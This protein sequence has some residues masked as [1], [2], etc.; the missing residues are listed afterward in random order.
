MQQ[1][2]FSNNLQNKYPFKQKKRDEKECSNQ[3]SIL[4]SSL[5]ASAL[6]YADNKLVSKVPNSFTKSILQKIER[7]T[8][9]I[10]PDEL[11]KFEEDFDKIF[12]KSKLQDCGVSVFKCNDFIKDADKIKEHLKKHIEPKWLNKYPFESYYNTILTHLKTENSCYA[13]FDKTIYSSKTTRL[14]LFHEMGHAYNHNKT[15]FAKTLQ[16]LRPLYKLISVP[17]S[18]A[19]IM[20]PDLAKYIPKKNDEVV[21]KKQSAMDKLVKFEHFFV[22]ASPLVV[23]ASFLPMIVEEGL[24]S[25][26]GQKFAKKILDQNMLN[27]V[28]RVNLFGF[29]SYLFYGVFAS[30]ILWTALKIKN[31]IDD[32][33]FNKT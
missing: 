16:K 33:L 27:K 19:A 20:L 25:L 29:C 4:L 24:A 1:I 12:K 18:I 22:K 11:K 7:I 31:I 5:A 6:C 15:I 21:S 14:S 8:K 28:K 3:D 23:F 26:Q 17:V 32:K 10:S 30:S 2:N 13:F 9:K